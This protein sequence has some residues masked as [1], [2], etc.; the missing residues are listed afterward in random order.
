LSLFGLILLLWRNFSLTSLLFGFHHD[1]GSKQN[2]YASNASAA[3]SATVS[4]QQQQRQRHNIQNETVLLR[5]QPPFRD[6][7]PPTVA[8]DRIYY[9]NWDSY[10]ERRKTMGIWLK[11]Q[12][13][14]YKRIRAVGPAN[15]RLYPCIPEIT[16]NSRSN[17][18]WETVAH[19]LSNIQI[20]AKYNKTGLSLVLADDFVVENMTRLIQSLEQLVLSNFDVVRW[21]CCAR[22]HPDFPRINSHVFRTGPQ[23]EAQEKNATTTKLPS[24]YYYGKNDHD[25]TYG[26]DQ[27][28]GGFCAM[29]WRDSSVHKL[30]ELWSEKPY[31]DIDCRLTTRKIKSYCVNN[32]AGIEALP[33]FETKVLGNQSSLPSGNPKDVP[34][35]EQGSTGL[36]RIYYINMKKNRRR[37]ELMES[38]LSKQGIHYQRIEATVGTDNHTCGGWAQE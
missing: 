32:V 26:D 13:I 38:Q 4:R 10:T 23:Q 30:C 29:I 17:R 5:E 31:A 16:K 34:V 18:C 24:S 3:G 22:P 2:V 12:P 21:N 7:N 33:V 9:V 1:G 25:Y 35:N 20:M 27:W 15:E 19:V 11:K 37:R 28:C 36:D 8:I 6:S 14:P